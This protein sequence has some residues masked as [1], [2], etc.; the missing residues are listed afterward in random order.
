MANFLKTPPIPVAHFRTPFLGFS[1]TFIYGYLSEL[2][3]GVRPVVYTTERLNGE[4][5]PFE[6]VVDYSRRAFSGSWTADQIAKR[7]FQVKDWS[8]G[9]RLRKG[10]VRLMH[11]HFGEEGYALVHVRKSLN[12]PLITTF[13]GYDVSEL[14]RIPEWREK[15]KVLF[16]E[17]DLFLVEGNHMKKSL[18]GLGCPESKIRVQHIAIPVDGIAFRRRGAK[19]AGQ[20]AVLLFCG[21]FVEKKGL[22]DA[23][24]ALKIVMDQGRKNFEYRVIGDGPL[25][26][27]LRAFVRENGLETNVRFLGRKSHKE[28][29]S[30]LQSADIFLSPSVTA[31]NGDSEGG[32][33]TTILEAQ[34]AGLPILSTRHAD[35]PEIVVEGSSALL[36]DERDVPALAK[37]IE[38]LLANPDS[39]GPMGET[40]RRHV[41]NG[42]NLRTEAVKLEKIYRELAS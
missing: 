3:R 1:E 14:G 17:G 27:E 35:I 30:E 8:L 32:A 26:E 31:A 13:Y 11:A 24:K 21:R 19:T 12:V 42:Y 7:I 15:Y 4:A 39:W 29:Y 25:N 23:L 34:A 10:G 28:F 38:K 5:F 18:M 37:N 20:P 2:K 22:M 33:P 36:C 6:D 9:R 16:R 41:E 40:G